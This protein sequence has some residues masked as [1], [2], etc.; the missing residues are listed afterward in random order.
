MLRILPQLGK[1]DID[2][3]SPLEKRMMQMFYV[4][5]WQETAENWDDPRVKKNI[6]DLASCK[7]LVKEIIDIL[8]IKYDEVDIIDK[9]VDVGFECPLDLYC[10][11]TRDQILVAMDFMKPNTVREGT[12]WLEDK[13][14]DVFFVTLN[15]SDKDYS[16]TTMY[17]DYSI[18][19]EFFH[20]QS[21]STTSDTSPTGQRYINHVCECSKVLL[22]VREFK[23]D[24][25]GAAPYTYLG[26]AKYV[27]HYGSR[28]MSI[29]WHLDNPIPAKYIKKTSKLEVG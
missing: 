11:Y 9:P 1:I 23:K 12:K 10:T 17:E 13:K 16:P 20:W 5:I 25:A 2:A 22:F 7:L 28:P 26:T 24:L 29:T 21:Q 15:K 3:L 6:S 14:V 8:E 18:N 19:E 4:T 27:S